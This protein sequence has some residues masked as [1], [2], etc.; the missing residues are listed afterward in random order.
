MKKNAIS[1]L[2]LVKFEFVTEKNAIGLVIANSDHR[3]FVTKKNAIS[4]LIVKFEIWICHRKKCYWASNSELGSYMI[5]HKKNAISHLMVKFEKNVI[6]SGM[7]NE[8]RGA[9]AFGGHIL[10]L[11]Q[12]KMLL[13]I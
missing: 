4:H 5:C 9:F 13:G 3:W 1:P 7:G 11:S 12:K 6:A 10:N 8:G 2:I